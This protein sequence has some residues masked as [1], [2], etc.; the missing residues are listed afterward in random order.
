MLHGTFKEVTH[1]ASLH[2]RI[3]P[4]T[5][6]TLQLTATCIDIHT[7]PLHISHMHLL[8]C[9]DSLVNQTQVLAWSAGLNAYTLH[10]VTNTR[11]VHL[12]LQ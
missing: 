4:Y 5:L 10:C 8:S 7:V 9:G 6:A 1:M 11:T 12:H 2:A 3:P